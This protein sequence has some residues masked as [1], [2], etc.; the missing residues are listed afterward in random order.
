MIKS[1]LIPP[2][3]FQIHQSPW[4]N[5]VSVRGTINATCDVSESHNISI[6]LYAWILNRFLLQKYSVSIRYLL[7]YEPWRTPTWPGHV[8]A[9]E[10]VLCSSKNN[11]LERTTLEWI[12]FCEDF[13]Q[14][15]PGSGPLAEDRK[16]AWVIAVFFRI[17]KYSF[18]AG[19]SSFPSWD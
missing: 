3:A 16:K 6:P 10:I 15:F 9:A 17:S 2:G 14:P 8:L 4:V 19:F 5:D 13:P 1:F 18:R 12:D 7:K 11:S